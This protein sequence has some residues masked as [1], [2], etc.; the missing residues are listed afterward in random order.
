MRLPRKSVW[1]EMRRGPRTDCWGTPV[2]R[3]QEDEGV[4]TRQSEGKILIRK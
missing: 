3:G 1:I 2:V 4:K